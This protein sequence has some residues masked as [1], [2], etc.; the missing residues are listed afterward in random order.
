MV[1]LLLSSQ[2]LFVP[3]L[4]ICAD[5][6]TIEV[7]PPPP[8][9]AG[10]GLPIPVKRPAYFR[11][12]LAIFYV[13]SALGALGLPLS[14]TYPA[15]WQILTGLLADGSRLA[16]GAFACTIFG[17]VLALALVIQSLA[18][19]LHDERR[20]VVGADTRSYWSLVVPGGLG[21]SLLVAGFYPR[22]LSPWINHFT[23]GL[24]PVAQ[25]PATLDRN[26]FGPGGWFGLALL[27]GVL[28]AFGLFRRWRRV[29][30]LAA[31]NGGLLYGSEDELEAARRDWTKLRGREQRSLVAAQE[32]LPTGFEDEFFRSGFRAPTVVVPKTA[33]RLPAAEFLGPLNSRLSLFYR[34]LD[35]GFSGNLFARLSLRGLSW[36]RFAFEWL[37]ERFYAALA[38][39][40]L[41]ILI[42]LL[43]R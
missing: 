12:L 36:L 32:A 11:A 34:L 25:P 5:L 38:A 40:L 10:K 24:L 8:N 17:L 19:F 29:A 21:L 18:Q 33:P 23:V 22:I 13:V 6:L 43:T 14:P 39:F 26:L 9:P 30:V 37:T 3:A 2:A 28:V 1:G 27:G 16:L 35:P 20:T 41:I 7:A 31:F 15:H 4:F 42:I